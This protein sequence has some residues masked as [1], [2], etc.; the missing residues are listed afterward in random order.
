[1]SSTY[2]DI[3]NHIEPINLSEMDRV[4][5]MD[6]VDSKYVFHINQLPRFLEELKHDYQVLDVNS[7]RISRYESLYFDTPDFA[8]YHFHQRGKFNRFKFRIRKYVESNLFFFE[9][10]FKNNKGRTFKNRIVNNEFDYEANELI[11]EF[12]HKNTQYGIS[13]LEQKIRVDY[14]RITLV[15]RKIAERVTIDLNLTFIQDGLSQTLET[16]V[17]AEVKQNKASIS[18]FVQLMHKNHIREG[19]ISKYCLGV[20]NL[21]PHLRANNFKPFQNNLKKIIKTEEQYVYR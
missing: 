10:K 7:T 13:D 4:S 20:M 19:S 14:S 21:Y 3:L 2:I 6:R 16:F 5:L 17:I 18:P 11:N 9:I 8:L 12:L 15:N 1:M